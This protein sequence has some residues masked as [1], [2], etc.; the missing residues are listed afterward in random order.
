M[1]LWFGNRQT[2]FSWWCDSICRLT[3]LQA[4]G[5]EGLSTSWWDKSRLEAV[6]ADTLV[7]EVSWPGNPHSPLP[8]TEDNW[9]D[10]S[11]S[12]R[13]QIQ[14]SICLVCHSGRSGTGLREEETEYLVE[15][16]WIFSMSGTRW[17]IREELRGKSQMVGLQEKEFDYAIGSNGRKRSLWVARFIRLQTLPFM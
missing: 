3:W 7:T 10:G 16:F 14:A 2:E 9:R 17:A 1:G 11:P 6:S 15:I 4:G 12:K 8:S 13:R 5:R